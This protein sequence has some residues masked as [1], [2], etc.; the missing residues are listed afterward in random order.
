M[1]ISRL[2]L[3]DPYVHHLLTSV[4]V[5]LGGEVRGHRSAPERGN[6]GDELSEST[7]GH[8]TDLS[9]PVPSPRLRAFG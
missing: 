4:Q 9:R 7:T 3:F 2:T 8:T 6:M 5:E 1:I